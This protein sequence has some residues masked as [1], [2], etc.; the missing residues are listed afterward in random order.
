[1]GVSPGERRGRRGWRP[2]RRWRKAPLLLGGR[3]FSRVRGRGQ[4]RNPARKPPS[5][6]RPPPLKPGGAESLGS[7]PGARSRKSRPHADVTDAGRGRRRLRGGGERAEAGAAR[8]ARERRR[9]AVLREGSGDP[10]RCSELKELHSWGPAL[11]PGSLRDARGGAGSRSP[12]P[13]PHA[14][15]RGIS[16]R[17]ARLLPSPGSLRPLFLPEGSC[18][19]PRVPSCRPCR[20]HG[21]RGLLPARRPWRLGPRVGSRRSR[22]ANGQVRTRPGRECFPAPPDPDPTLGTW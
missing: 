3:D 7:S 6:C 18:R 8:A 14:A 11:A 16:L 12:S 9:W 5:A 1:M 2:R 20:G 15:S 10:Q 17:F 4:S 21:S 22:R 19:L 13:P